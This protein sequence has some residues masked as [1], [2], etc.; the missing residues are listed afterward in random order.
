M[1]ASGVLCHRRK[2]RRVVTYA[3]CGAESC[4]SAE[5]RVPNN[6]INEQKLR[7]ANKELREKVVEVKAKLEKVSQELTDKIE[8]YKPDMSMSSNGGET[9]SSDKADSVEFVSAK[10]DV[11]TAFKVSATKELKD[12]RSRLDKTSEACACIQKSIDA[13]ESYSY[14]FNIKIVGIPIAAERERSEQTANLCLQL[15]SA[16]GVKGVLIND[17]DTT[18]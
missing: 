1:H 11:L 3:V 5:L 16:L 2:C 17:I 8:E 10:Y 13:F 4:T 14:Q 6:M 12:I 18:H 15:F 9:L 7:K